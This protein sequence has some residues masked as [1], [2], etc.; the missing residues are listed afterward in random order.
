[1]LF[2]ELYKSTGRA[3][4]FSEEKLQTKSKGSY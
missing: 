4:A 1:M 3:G 2:E